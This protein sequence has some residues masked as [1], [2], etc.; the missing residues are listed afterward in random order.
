MIVVKAAERGRSLLSQM[1][2]GP[3]L[4]RDGYKRKQRPLF[5]QLFDYLITVSKNMAKDAGI[6]P[7]PSEVITALTN[8]ALLFI[9]FQL[10]DWN[11][12][13]LFRFVMNLEGGMGKKQSNVAVQIRPEVGRFQIPEDARTY[14]EN[15][16]LKGSRFINMSIYWGN[17]QEFV[18]E[19]GRQWGG[20]SK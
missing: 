18:K 4:K 17:S 19:L 13:V 8:T 14:M 2:W 3:P 7:I 1:R 20:K 11:F 9:G 5:D 12:G 10:E 6:R 16:F 15:Y